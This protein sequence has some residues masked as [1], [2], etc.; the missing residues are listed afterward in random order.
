MANT[1]RDAAE[2]AIADAVK[3]HVNDDGLVT[4]YPVDPEQYDVGRV[5]GHSAI[6]HDVE[7][8]EAL[9]VLL[10]RPA[11]FT[12]YE[13]GHPLKEHA[14]LDRLD[15]EQAWAE[16][17]D[18]PAPNQLEAMTRAELADLADAAGLAIKSRATKAE[19][20]AAL[21]AEHTS[22][23]SGAQ[24]TSGAAPEQQQSAPGG[25]QNAEA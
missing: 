22:A 19:L 25:A 17:V 15:H 12:L 5:E 23:E 14:E 9:A 8:D 6:E 24:P 10:M 7:P 4:L 16:P 3:G 11:A 20:I 13:S 21:S 2:Q 1:E 18:V